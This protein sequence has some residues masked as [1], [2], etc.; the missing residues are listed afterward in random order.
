[1]SRIMLDGWGR[2]EPDG[3]VWMP[4]HHKDYEALLD[5]TMLRTHPH[6]RRWVPRP[7]PAI[8]SVE[9][10][11]DTL[12]G[13]T[14]VVYGKGRSL[15]QYPFE[16]PENSI[17]INETVLVKNC[18]FGFALDHNVFKRIKGYSKTLIVNAKNVGRPFPHLMF[19][20]WGHH[21]TVGYESAPCVLEILA[22]WGVKDVRLVGFDSLWLN[23]THVGYAEVL[24]ELPPRGSEDYAPINRH[25]EE[26]II[27]HGLSVEVWGAP[28]GWTRPHFSELAEADPEVVEEGLHTLD[29]DV[30]AGVGTLPDD[31][32]EV[33]HD[34][35]PLPV[36]E[37]E[38][39]DPP[40]VT[41]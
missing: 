17:G 5:R 36:D 20:D 13:Q 26:V 2:L 38:D 33:G 40:L 3:T 4:Q 29:A 16:H 18:R 30:E 6:E 27:R 31:N 11:R 10:L 28:S 23:D 39:E 34:P 32:I 37:V 35:S 22:M 1:M 9:Q 14:W 15:D 24:G 8:V 19:F 12:Q 25:L 21:V 41:D 7:E